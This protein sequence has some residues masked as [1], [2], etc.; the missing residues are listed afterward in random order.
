MAYVSFLGHFRWNLTIFSKFL[1]CDGTCNEKNLR[2]VQKLSSKWILINPK[3]T[4]VQFQIHWNTLYF[5]IRN[6]LVVFI[7]ITSIWTCTFLCRYCALFYRLL[8]L[9]CDSF[10]N[11]II[12]T[13][14]FVKCKYNVM[15]VHVVFW[16][17][18]VANQIIIIV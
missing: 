4:S 6:T 5:N 14:G 12:W 18:F 13:D 15:F 11:L 17:I 1:W 2:F 8:T 7:C 16:Y 9:C 10:W 3:K